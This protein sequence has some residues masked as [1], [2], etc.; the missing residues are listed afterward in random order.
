MINK[1]TTMANA[2][3]EVKNGDTILIGGFGP[4]GTP[5]NLV[6][7][8]SARDLSDLTVVA[9]AP[10]QVLCW[11][12]PESV[13][14]V[15][16]TIP[17]YP[18]SSWRCGPL[19]DAVRLGRVKSEV[20]PQGTFAERM[21]AAGAGI[22]AFYTPVGVGTL[23]GEG[24]QTAIFNGR[25]CL[26]ET[27]LPGDVALIKGDKADRLGNV[28]YRMAQRNF[29]PVMAQAGRVTIVEVDEVVEVGQLK[30]EEIVTPGIFIKWVVK[31]PKRI[32]KYK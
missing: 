8:V 7:A 31:V 21:R 15:I 6:E 32:I 11:S 1:V 19:T 29:N 14:K 10:S 9:N 18:Y 22:P 26:L 27:A 28:V 17:V 13:I 5:H 2:I 20:V 4:A 16:A 23:L 25:R 3:T 24:H 30:P 12:R